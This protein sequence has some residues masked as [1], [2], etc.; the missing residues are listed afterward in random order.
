[1]RDQ[2]G[3]FEAVEVKDEIARVEHELEALE[4]Q[5][6]KD[7]AAHAHAHA[8]DAERETG[9]DASV[10]VIG[11]LLCIALLFIAFVTEGW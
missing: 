9:S 1:M 2:K 11:V 10:L 5:R 4:A 8:H 6:E 7:K 3:H